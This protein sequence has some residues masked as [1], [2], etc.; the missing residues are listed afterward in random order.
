MKRQYNALLKGLAAFV[1]FLV[2]LTVVTLFFYP[3]WSPDTEKNPSAGFYYEEPNSIDV[4]LLGSCNLYTSFS[5]NLFYE[6][7]GITSYC[8]SCPDQTYLTSYYYLKESLK[9]Q[10]PKVVVI[11]ALFLT[12]RDTAK[13]EHYN[14]EAADYLRPSLEKLVLCYHLARTEGPVLESYGEQPPD[15]LTR[16]AGYLF[17]LLRYHARDDINILKDVGFFLVKKPYSHYKGS[18]PFFSYANVDGLDYPAIYNTNAIRED[19]KTYLPRI[20]QLCEENGIPLVIMKSPNHW[21]WNEEY[22]AVAKEYVTSCGLPFIDVDDGG[23]GTYPEYYYQDHTGRLNIYGMR[24]LT[25]YFGKYLVDSYGLTPTALNDKSTNRWQDCVSYL[26]AKAKEKNMDLTRGEIAQLRCDEGGILVRWNPYADCDTYTVL[27]SVDGGTEETIAQVAG[28]MYIDCSNTS[29]D[30]TT[31]RVVPDYGEHA[32]IASA[33][34]QYRF[35]EV[36]TSFRAVKEDDT[37]KLSWDKTDGAT[38]Y[39]IQQMPDSYRFTD[40]A[41][42]TECGYTA[43]ADTAGFFGRYRLRAVL[44]ADGE[45]YYSDGVVAV[46][47]S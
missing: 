19:V 14:R 3:K 40:L 37:V 28:N 24:E 5:P 22:T 38:G 44:E 43:S 11:E 35:V 17:P 1:G 26:Y 18:V 7:Y 31:Y 2:L 45:K 13:R 27:R 8:R 47:E 34:K 42:T 23:F 15:F 29:G 39:V 46:I 36:P 10:K 41:E 6:E 30:L 4:L 32:E 20:Q 33:P 9:T 25:H 16:F 21:R 12:N